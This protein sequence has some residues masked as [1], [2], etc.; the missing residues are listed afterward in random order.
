MVRRSAALTELQ[1][2]LTSDLNS[3]LSCFYLVLVVRRFAVVEKHL[4][5]FGRAPLRGKPAFEVFWPQ[6][7]DHPIMSRRP[8]FGRRLVGDCCEREQRACLR[9]LPFTEEAS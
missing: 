3:S 8:H 1:H 7:D 4:Q 9:I 6:T 5:R 2:E